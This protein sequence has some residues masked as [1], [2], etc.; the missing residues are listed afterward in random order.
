MKTI[1]LTKNF[2]P[3]VV[4]TTTPGDVYGCPVN[5]DCRRLTARRF[6]LAAERL[7]VTS[8][9]VVGLLDAI[10]GVCVDGHYDG[11]SIGSWYGLVGLEYM[12]KTVD[13]NL[14]TRKICPEC[15]VVHWASAEWIGGEICVD[16]S[17]AF[18]GGFG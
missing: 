12:E 5:G 17:M 16:C 15:G 14:L 2:L 7:G 6:C 13:P 18:V 3:V 4:E 9:F 8:T 10:T 11:R 1:Y